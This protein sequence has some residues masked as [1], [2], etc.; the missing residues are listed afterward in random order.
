MK[1]KTK[2]KANSQNIERL[3]IETLKLAKKNPRY[4]SEANIAKIARSIETYGWTTPALVTDKLEVIAGH[5]RI[6]AART[7]GLT[8]VPCIR[9]GHLTPKLAE[10]YRIADNRLGLDSDWDEE[11]LG[12]VLKEMKSDIEWDEL[13]TGFSQVEIMSRLGLDLGEEWFDMP[14]FEHGEKAAFRSV[15]VHF[16]DQ[17]AVDQFA[18]LLEVTVTAKTKYVWFPRQSRTDNRGVRYKAS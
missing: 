16:N 11:M 6:Y 12:S 13:F 10:A 7:L 1:A 14:E 5:G 3:N 15:M 17:Q 8:E 18:A 9:L 2:A 4:H